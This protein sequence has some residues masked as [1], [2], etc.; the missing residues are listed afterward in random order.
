MVIIVGHGCEREDVACNK[1]MYEASRSAVFL[2][3]EKSAVF[4]LAIEQGVAQG[5]TNVNLRILLMIC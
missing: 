3:G 5:I 2:K 4:R 1:K